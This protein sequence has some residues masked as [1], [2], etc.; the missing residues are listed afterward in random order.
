MNLN[1]LAGHTFARADATASPRARPPAAEDATLLAGLLQ[2]FR[3][4]TL[5]KSS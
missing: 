1:Q 2:T 4:V 3:A 5:V